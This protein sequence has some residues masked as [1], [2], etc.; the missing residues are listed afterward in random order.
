MIRCGDNVPV[1]SLDAIRTTV[2]RFTGVVLPRESET[3]I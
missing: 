2:T 3:E 1:G